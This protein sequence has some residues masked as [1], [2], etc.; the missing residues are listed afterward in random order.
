MPENLKILFP[1]DKIRNIQDTVVSD[2]CDAL[3]N[4]RSMIIHAP[5]GIGKTASVLAPALSFALDKEL[6][7]FFLT[8]RQT[9]HKIAVDTLKQI[10]KKHGNDFGVVD[11]IGKKWMCLQEADALQNSDFLEYCKKLRDKD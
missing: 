11:L 5:T 4:K 7:V 9:Q 2:V 8:S 1:H 6:T 3:K 10:K